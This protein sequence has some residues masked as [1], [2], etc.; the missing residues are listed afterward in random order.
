LYA[1]HRHGYSRSRIFSTMMVAATPKTKATRPV[2]IR[3]SMVML[4][5]GCETKIG[6]VGLIQA[7]HIP[8]S[9]GPDFLPV[10]VAGKLDQVQ[11]LGALVLGKNQVF[12]DELRTPGA[13][14]AACFA[15]LL[16]GGRPG[17][18]DLIRLAVGV[19]ACPVVAAGERAHA[20]G[21]LIAPARDG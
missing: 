2:P 7:R 17:A 11:I 14:L 21:V 3:Y 20:G 1:T 9:D 6:A 4:L 5:C 12:G 19:R 10:G 15:H 16:S 13:A 18:G 8:L